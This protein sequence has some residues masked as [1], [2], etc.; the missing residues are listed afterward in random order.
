MTRT[1]TKSVTMSEAKTRKTK[2]MPPLNLRTDSNAIVE[3]GKV[4][5]NACFVYDVQ[6][7]TK[8]IHLP[9]EQKS[10][11]VE[12]VVHIPKTKGGKPLF[13][14]NKK[15]LNMS[16]TAISVTNMTSIV[17]TCVKTIIFRKCKFYYRDV[18]GRYSTKENTMCGQIVKHC[19]ITDPNED[20]W[21]QIRPIV[22]NTITDHRNNCIKAIQ[23]RFSGTFSW[24]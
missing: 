16:M 13:T 14:D 2:R 7:T 10:I 1:S 15:T 19:N 21:Y 12:R 3:Q 9:D 11:A 20:W 24:T 8:Q 17:K 22:V 4:S 23:K 6:N 18:H 5:D